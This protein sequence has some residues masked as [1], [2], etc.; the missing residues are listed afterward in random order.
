MITV[1]KNDD[2]NDW[3]I[4]VVVNNRQNQIVRREVKYL[5]IKSLNSKTY[6]IKT[7]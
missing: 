7:I 2:Y 6:R 4:A 3:I 1:R 5:K